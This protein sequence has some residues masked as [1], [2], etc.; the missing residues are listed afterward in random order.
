MWK[1]NNWK[2]KILDFIFPRKCAFCNCR[3]KEDYTCKKCKKNLEY[4]CIPETNLIEENKR[5]KSKREKNQF[6]S[7]FCSYFYEG[8]IREKILAF[9]FQNKKYLYLALSERLIALLQN[10]KET[11]D[12]VLS[13]PI[14]WERYFERGYNQSALIAKQIALSLQ[15]P[16]EKHILVKKKNNE[17]QSTLSLLKRKKNVQGVYDIWQKEKIKGKNI[18]LID[19]ILTTGATLNECS[20]ILKENGAR[21]VLVGVIARAKIHKK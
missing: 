16:Y 11:I 6:D 12:L 9:K 18:L 7:C 15:K 14:S 10:Q 2:E 1:E 4:I 19:D 21:Q 20:R 13:V 8:I 3:I 17:K 5:E